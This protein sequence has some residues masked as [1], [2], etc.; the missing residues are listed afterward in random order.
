MSLVRNCPEVPTRLQF[1]VDQRRLRSETGFSS[2]YSHCIEPRLVKCYDRCLKYLRPTTPQQ[3]ETDIQLSIDVRSVTDIPTDTDIQ[4]D[5]GSP[6]QDTNANT[7]QDLNYYGQTSH[8]QEDAHMGLDAEFP[9]QQ[10][11][12]TTTL[13][14]KRRFELAEELDK[15]LENISLATSP[16]PAR[17]R[18]RLS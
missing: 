8:Q 5:P 3:L 12:S 18:L 13:S 4:L 14:K 9:K 10:A 6:T 2:L 17:N 11:S 7:A 1:A 16:R 15:D